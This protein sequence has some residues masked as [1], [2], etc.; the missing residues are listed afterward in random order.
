[1]TTSVSY[2]VD[3]DV[4]IEV[5]RGKHAAREY[6][7]SLPVWWAISRVSAMELIVGARDK[8]EVDNI[9]KFLS[10]FAILPFGDSTGTLAYELL[11]RHAKSHGLQVFDSLIAATAI[12]NNLTLMTRN[13]RHFDMIDGLSLEIPKY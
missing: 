7:D 12:E 11:K 10:G 8:R 13:Q 5:S 6:F 1:L 4:L 9:H 3:S 2:L